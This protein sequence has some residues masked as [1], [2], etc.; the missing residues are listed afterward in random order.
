M[1]TKSQLY[2]ELNNILSSS[3][4]LLQYINLESLSI[5]NKELIDEIDNNNETSS[6]LKSLCKQQLY[7]EQLNKKIEGYLNDIRFIIFD[8]IDNPI[9]VKQKCDFIFKE[10]QNLHQLFKQLGLK[11]KIENIEFKKQDFEFISILNEIQKNHLSRNSI[12]HKY[13]LIEQYLTKQKVDESKIDIYGKM[14]IQN[15]CYN[16]STKISIIN[17]EICSKYAEDLFLDYVLLEDGNFL[18]LSPLSLKSDDKQQK[19]TVRELKPDEARFFNS[20]EAYD[21]FIKCKN[22]IKSRGKIRKSN[23]DEI[24]SLSD[25]NKYSCIFHFMVLKKL[26][27]LETKHSTFLQYLIEKHDAI[28]PKNQPK[29][30]HRYSD[31]DRVLIEEWYKYDFG[32]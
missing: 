11:F 25:L 23:I 1:K 15:F 29:F 18:L 12:N 22:G 24:Q 6:S 7:I 9:D 30:P 4:N 16:I 2:I 20:I 28:I 21:F 13:Q 32:K 17:T 3:N 19:Q 5:K 31:S 27:F 14:L 8:K 26:I 10:N